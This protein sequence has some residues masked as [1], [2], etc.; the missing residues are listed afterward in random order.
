[1]AGVAPYRAAGLDWGAGMGPENIAEFA[2][3]A[4]GEEALTRFLAQAAAELSG[5]TGEKVVAGLGG[6]VSA[7]D[8]TVVTGEFA[9]YLAASFRAALRGGLAGWRDDDLA[10]IGDWGFPVSGSGVPVAIWQGDEDLMVPLRHGRWLAEQ[11]TGA[12]AHMRRGEGH[13]TLAAATFGAV[14]DDLLDLAGLPPVSLV[15]SG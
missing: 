6:L 4:A 13:L 12:R 3:A 10:F 8:S 9:D 2:A 7:V 5:I 14:L 11:V 1:M 15:R